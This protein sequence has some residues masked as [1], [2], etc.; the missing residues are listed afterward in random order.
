MKAKAVRNQK[1]YD[2]LIE[3]YAKSKTPCTLQ[4]V[5]DEFG[6]SL[7]HIHEFCN[8]HGIKK[9]KEAI[10]DLIRELKGLGF[11]VTYIARIIGVTPSAVSI[12]IKNMKRKGLMKDVE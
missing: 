6:L 3:N 4:Q 8:K 10:D 12:R 11:S 5:A 7:G 2:Y 9:N 1:L